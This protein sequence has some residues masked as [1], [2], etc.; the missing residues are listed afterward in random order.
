MKEN[1]FFSEHAIHLATACAVLALL[2]FIPASVVKT[3]GVRVFFF[4]MV[5][6]LMVGGCVI[7]YLSHRTKGGRIHY[8]LY[9][10]RRNTVLP[11]SALNFELIRDSVD[12]Y[13]SEY[14]E[15]ALS[16]WKEIPKKL[17]IRL[18][19]EPQFKPLIAY[20]MLAELSTKDPENILDTF[21]NADDR[22]VGY[23]CRAIHDSDDADMA[24]YL[25]ELKKNIEHDRARI[26]VF[27]N[28]NRRCFEERMLR[29][30]ERHFEEFYI[31]KADQK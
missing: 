6:L 3:T 27:F 2:L 20:R 9:D 31:N 24:D 10:R 1:K 30:V 14:I 11:K 25:F 21:S 22:A 8:F 16:L 26:S 12:C 15:N 29:Y 23:I 7:L 19:E 4:V 17:R 13:L 18:E 5:A 28:K